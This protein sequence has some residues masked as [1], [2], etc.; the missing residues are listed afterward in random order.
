MHELKDE[1]V[2][3]VS[4]CATHQRGGQQTGKVCGCVIAIHRPTGIAMRVDSERS[5]H[6]NRVL[7]VRRLRDL[8]TPI[9]T[10]HGDATPELVE[11]LRSERAQF[12]KLP[13]DIRIVRSKPDPRVT[14]VARAHLASTDCTDAH[15]TASILAEE[16]VRLAT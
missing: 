6:A 10:V 2:D 12:F 5:Q 9:V 8:M 4:G 7:A 16:I 3:V 13:G 14:E 1:D 15:L 11:K